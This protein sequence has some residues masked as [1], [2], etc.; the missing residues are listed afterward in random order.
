M[1]QC[2]VIIYQGQHSLLCYSIQIFNICV[3]FVKK[4][5][6]P[7]LWRNSYES[8]ILSVDEKLSSISVA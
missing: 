1:E 2:L 5:K 7:I 3:L 4:K 8:V 6:A